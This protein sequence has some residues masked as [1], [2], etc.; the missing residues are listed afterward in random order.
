[1]TF[2]IP[3]GLPFLAYDWLVNVQLHGQSGSY[4]FWPAL[5]AGG[6]DPT[7]LVPLGDFAA[8]RDWLE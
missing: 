1:M 4:G 5:I 2:P 3:K 6:S 8:Y 7:V